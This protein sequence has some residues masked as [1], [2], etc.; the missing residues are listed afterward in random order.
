MC[1]GCDDIKIIE[2]LPSAEKTGKW[3]F[4]GDNLFQCTHCGVMYTTD[5]LNVWRN[6]SSDPYAPKW[7][8]HCG[9]KMSG[10]E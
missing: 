4:V 1:D 2:S 10:D 8:P 6:N 7:C 3:N 5:Q 9:A